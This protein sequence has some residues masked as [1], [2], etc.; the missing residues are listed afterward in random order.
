MCYFYSLWGVGHGQAD[1][2]ATREGEEHHDEGEGSVVGEE[3]GEVGAPL[4]VTEHQQR[5]KHHPGDH[6]HREQMTLLGRLRNKYREK[7]Y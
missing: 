1:A 6:Q 7:C 3:D 5:N 4:D 2:V